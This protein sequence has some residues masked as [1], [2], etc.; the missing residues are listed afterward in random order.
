MSAA[1]LNLRLIDRML[2]DPVAELQRRASDSERKTPP[3]PRRRV[4]Y[5]RC[6]CGVMAEELVGLAKEAL[7]GWVRRTHAELAGKCRSRR[8]LYGW[9]QE[10][11]RPGPRLG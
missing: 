11:E 10:G 5:F 9:R 1:N 8:W 6:D 7:E 2:D 3:C 4:F